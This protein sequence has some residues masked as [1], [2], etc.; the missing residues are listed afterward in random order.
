[1]N[2]ALPWLMFLSLSKDSSP[3]PSLANLKETIMLKRFIGLVIV[4]LGFGYLWAKAFTA[5][6]A[7]LAPTPQERLV[8]FGLIV[9]GVFILWV[10]FSPK[11]NGNG[12]K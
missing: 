2:S 5:D 9:I 12:Q 10:I 4:F 6:V 7:L 11:E 8:K 3:E 1:M